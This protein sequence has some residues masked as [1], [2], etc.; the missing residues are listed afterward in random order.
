MSTDFIESKLTKNEKI[1][2]VLK[3]MRQLDASTQSKST[4]NLSMLD[5]Q[6]I[7]EFFPGKPLNFK[8]QFVLWQSPEGRVVDFN[9]FA[10]RFGSGRTIECSKNEFISNIFPL[11][12][13]DKYMQ[14]I[15]NALELKSTVVLNMKL[16]H[17]DFGVLDLALSFNPVLSQTAQLEGVLTWG[18]LACKL[19]EMNFLDVYR[20]L[21]LGAGAI[22]IRQKI[23]NINTPR[24]M[25]KLTARQA[26][27]LLYLFIGNTA[28]EI[29]KN[30]HLS[31]RSVEA[32]IAKLKEIVGCSSS[33]SLV[34]FFYEVKFL[35]YF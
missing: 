11:R 28:K 3:H 26:E 12:Y 31:P 27:V 16:P 17:Y 7:R 2:M 14:A 9:S 6:W 25:I 29:A 32:S 4:T 1:R 30:M 10:G 13:A 34:Q 20:L 24:G 21:H 15:K 33:S 5:V 19:S 35:N 8:N 18:D 23:Y 22:F